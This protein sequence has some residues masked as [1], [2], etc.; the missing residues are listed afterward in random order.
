[1][2]HSH[3][4]TGDAL[5]SLP[6]PELR[7]APSAELTPQEAARQRE[8]DDFVLRTYNERGY[9]I[10]KTTQTY[11]G[12]I[13]DWLDPDSV[14]GSRK[15]PPSSNILPPPGGEASRAERQ[16]L[17]EFDLYPEVRGPE[18][19]VPMFRQSFPGYVAGTTG[20]RS[21]QEFLANLPSGQPV[22]EFRLYGGYRTGYGITGVYSEMQQFPNSDPVEANSFNILENA[23]G[24]NFGDPNTQF[25]GTIV[26]RGF[27]SD[28]GTTGGTLR[29]WTEF[30]TNGANVGNNVGGTSPLWAGF[31]P[32]AG[33]P[34]GPG[35]TLT[36]ISGVGSGTA[37]WWSPVLMFQSGGDYWLQ[38]NGHWLG[39]YAGSLFSGTSP[40]TDISTQ[41]CQAQWYG[42]VY[43][44]TPT[45]WTTTDMGS[46]QFSTQGSHFAS[47]HWTPY[48]VDTSGASQWPDVVSAFELLS[49]KTG[50]RT[51][52][53]CYTTSTPSTGSD[54]HF[55]LGGP[56]HVTGSNCN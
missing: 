53:A 29:L 55:Y 40:S 38:H 14:P 3:E 1:L 2:P 51:A 48:I 27:G 36:G 11:S 56:G 30:F 21:L 9:R 26:G 10:I 20:Y 31:T 49:W 39:Y 44:P 45:T 35:V 23:I 13:W 42:E 37:D 43:D 6:E 12:D 28:I 22:G 25:V 34:W 47:Y 52:G 46:G 41:S 16:A 19:T 33:A 5:S 8:V 24:C 54:R 50:N 15:Q 7:L 32:A 18:D 4:L 17:T